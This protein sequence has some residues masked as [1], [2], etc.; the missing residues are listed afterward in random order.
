MKERQKKS[1]LTGQVFS[2]L[3][4][5]NQEKERNNHNAIVYNCKCECG[6]IKKVISSKLRT[7]S[8]K[9]CG[10]LKIDK[11]ST[12][13]KSNSR[14]FKTWGAMLHRCMDN[15]FKNYSDRGITVCER[16]K[17]KNGFLNFLEDMGE[18]PTS[19]HSIDR[20]DVNGNYS[21]ENCRW[22]TSKEQGR[23]K[24]NNRLFTYKGFQRCSSEWCEI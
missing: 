3:T 2:R 22:A 5:L 17:G 10:C 12:H 18:R 23:N 24:T 8:T 19:K 20:I 9:S 21:P 1:D 11:I 13:G 7:G 16:W 4:V 6:K 14:E 15:N